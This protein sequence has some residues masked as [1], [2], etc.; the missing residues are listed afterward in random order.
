MIPEEEEER[1]VADDRMSSF[2]GAVRRTGRWR[3]SACLEIQR[4]LGRN[5][6]QTPFSLAQEPTHSPRLSQTLTFTFFPVEKFISVSENFHFQ[7]RRTFV[8]QTARCRM[9]RS[10]AQTDVT[11]AGAG[12]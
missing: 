12:S 2:R 7:G 9:Y 3:S 11:G 6:R 4:R 8:L 5:S 1:T 10:N